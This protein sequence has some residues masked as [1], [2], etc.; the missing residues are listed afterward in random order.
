ME[1]EPA[2]HFEERPT[3]YVDD[4]ENTDLENMLAVDTQGNKKGRYLDLKS[5]KHIHVASCE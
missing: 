3:R 2:E 1:Q 5:R 4:D